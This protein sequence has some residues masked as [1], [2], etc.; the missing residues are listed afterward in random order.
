MA[1]NNFYEWL[2][3]SV[4]KFESDVTRLEA[5]YDRC[6]KEWDSSK[7]IAMQNRSAIYKED[8]KKAIHDAVLW[9]QIYTDYKNSVDSNISKF[10][11][12]CG[13]EVSD[14]TIAKIAKRENVSEAYIK[15][16]V[17]AKGYNFSK[18]DD[19]KPQGGVTLDSIAPDATI[20]NTLDSI[21]KA[22]NELSFN[23]I[24]E[25]IMHETT[26]AISLDNCTKDEL[27]EAFK[28]IKQRWSRV[29]ASG[30]KHQQ[31]SH[32][33][34]ICSGM[35]SF[36]KKYEVSDYIK[37]LNWKKASNALDR[38]R[39]ELQGI[40]QS[41]L[42]DKTFNE[43]VDELYFIVGNRDSAKSIVEDYCFKK[44]IGYPKALPKVAVCPFCKNSFEKITPV[45]QS[46]PSCNHSFIVKCPK[47]GK[48]KNIITDSE[49]DGYDLQK[50]PLVLKKVEEAENSYKMLALAETK[51]RLADITK[52]WPGLQSVKDLTQKCDDAEKR[53][54]NDLKQ[55]QALC[56][57]NKYFAART[58]CDRLAAA[59]PECKR[60]FQ[61]IYSEIRQAE[62]MLQEYKKESSVDKKVNILLDLVQVVTDYTEANMELKKYP[63]EGVSGLKATTNYENGT[64]LVS[65]SSANK[66]NSV[67]Y[68]VRRK[69]GSPVANESDGEEIITTQ[70][71]SFNDSQVKEGE[72]YYYA[73]YATRG[74]ISSTLSVLNTPAVY[75]DEVTATFTVK[76]GGV[77]IS[78]H[79]GIGKVQVFYSEQRPISVFGEGKEWTKVTPSGCLIDNLKNGVTYYFAIYKSV[80]AGGKNYR[81][82]GLKQSCTPMV[83]IAPPAISKSIGKGDG[84]YIIT[85]DNYRDGDKLEFYYSEV[86]VGIAENVTVN[87]S[88]LQKK[89][90]RLQV[91]TP[92][93]DKYLINMKGM[94]EIII[95]PVILRNSMATIGNRLSLRYV[96]PIG[97][98]GHTLAGT[99][100]CINIEAW[101]DGADAIFVCYN[102]DVYPQDERD[103]D[104]KVQISKS[105]FLRSKM[106]EVPGI[107]QK[108]YYIGLFARKQADYIPI[109]NYFFDNRVMTKIYYSFASSFIGGCKIKIRCES[110]ERPELKLVTRNGCLPLTDKD[111]N[112]ALTIPEKKN[113]DSNET[114]SIPG[115]IQP[116]T[117]GKLFSAAGC[118]LILEGSAKIK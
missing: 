23:D 61:N 44:G 77:D 105:Q 27:L 11:D 90:K 13:E 64:I 2:G 114:F 19:K 18:S 107:L 47:C 29:S 1:E 38:V 69:T 62:L 25:L 52:L 92:E 113:A 68:H 93:K 31:K 87:L 36:F 85:H 74:P 22:V 40:G 7:S 111:G 76:D 102:D 71:Q 46:C 81:T 56:N 17:E 43:L 37:Y 58:I 15:K 39:A 53:Y 21:Q 110:A 48:D 63:V 3:L 86:L 20:R 98:T 32:Y 49:C 104:K 100:L 109:G 42:N 26:N 112:I 24:T 101:P 73:V 91:D 83:A 65:W 60:I 89:A 66:P 51:S 50:Y 117:Y 5:I 82:S 34:K 8:I 103:C 75:L 115:K 10:I 6:I 41:S 12:M 97:I 118:Q 45:Q 72:L 33:E 55:I 80:S 79:S 4:E 99:T 57:D 70:N 9:K 108:A 94:P 67:Y 95:Y 30:A 106:L 84:E 59:F 16:I 96:K 88:D 78:W 54:G 28:A 14:D 116:N 35:T